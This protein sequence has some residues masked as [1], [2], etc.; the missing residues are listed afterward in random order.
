MTRAVTPSGSVN[1]G[2]STWPTGRPNTTGPR[3]ARR[4]EASVARAVG[5]PHGS[6]HPGN[7]PSTI[8]AARERM[9]ASCSCVR[10]RS[11]RYGRSATSS[12]NSTQPSGGSNANGVPSDAAICVSVPPKI[13]PAASPGT[14]ASSA[15]AGSS[16]SGLDS[17]TA[18]RNVSRSYR[19]A[20]S[21]RRPS[22][23]GPWKTTCPSWPSQMCSDVMSL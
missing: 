23:I 8:A 1:A 12:M 2:P 10:R 7:V 11:S 6:S 17:V 9:P 19:S 5:S 15:G 22:S 13:G 3:N 21:A 20:P 4:T 18:R 16:P 14:S